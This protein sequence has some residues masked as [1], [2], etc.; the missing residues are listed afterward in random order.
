M[1][2]EYLNFIQELGNFV[3]TLFVVD[4]DYRIC[5]H[6]VF[7]QGGLAWE[8][9]SSIGK[10]PMEIFSGHSEEQCLTYRALRYNEIAIN[11]L[12]RVVYKGEEY[13][14]IVNTFLVRQNGRTVGAVTTG[15]ILDGDLARYSITVPE[16]LSLQKNRLYEVTDI[17]GQSQEM[18]LLRQKILKVAASDS[19]VFIHGE[20]G[21]GKELVAQSLHSHSPNRDGP[22]ISQ[23][24]AA[25]PQT[26]M[27]SLFFGT[28]RGSFT[29]AQNKPGIFEIADGGTVFLDELNSMD[30][31]MQA[32]LL[33]VIEEKT[34]TRVG[35]SAPKVIDVRI[36]SAINQS[37][38][39]CLLEGNLRPDLFYRLA[40][41]QIQLPPLRERRSDIHGLAMHFIRKFN[42]EM[43]TS[44]EGVSEAVMDAFNAYAWPGNVRE[45]R[46][47]IEGAFNSISGPF[48]ELDSLPDHL[49]RTEGET[50]APSGGKGE[51]LHQSL[52]R[53]EKA[54]IISKARQV[55]TLTDLADSLDI[56]RQVLTYK[57][58]KHGLKLF[59]A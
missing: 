52:D 58:K 8:E 15:Q 10:T 35:G 9:V 33:K 23:N 19:N 4:E 43:C 45:L 42:R 27:E 51:S 46:N 36:I 32:K 44:M 2:I 56:S 55:K 40:Q 54:V 16:P 20:T 11:K 5:S 29:G 31:S 41:V 3:D 1:E 6:K 12:V 26:L 21:T 14:S 47:V 13:K 57:L 18:T 39:C 28:T 30:L 17:I 24:C 59:G 38:D 49:R 34:I 48:I 22:F 50:E 37:P 7:R 25:I 53:F